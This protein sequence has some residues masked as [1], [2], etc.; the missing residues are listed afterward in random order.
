MAKAM[1]RR[2]KTL[3]PRAHSCA[4]IRRWKIRVFYDGW[5]PSC[6]QQVEWIRQL[7]WLGLVT[8]LSFRDEGLCQRFGLDP[9][10]AARR[11][12]A[13]AVATGRLWDGVDAVI[14]VVSRVVP[15]WP[16]LPA[17]L[18]LRLLGLG[19]RAYDWLA[20]RRLIVA[21]ACTGTHCELEQKKRT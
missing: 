20:S 21:P 10:R 11:I 1:R 16:L 2:T 9:A 3:V 18:V 12:H 4:W 14:Q 6:V 19:Q 13:Q 8:P 17:L 5:C 7:D 15:L